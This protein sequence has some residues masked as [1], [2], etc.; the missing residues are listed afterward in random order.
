MAKR[1]TIS[2]EIIISALLTCP[3]LDKAAQMCG[4]SVR[5]LYERRQDAAFMQK[6]AEAQTQALATT[7]RFLQH[8]TGSAAAALLEIVE[9]REQPAQVRVTAA[10][11]ILE[12]AIR[13]TETV[14][15]GER[16]DALERYAEGEA[17]NE[18]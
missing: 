13:L 4:L 18:P 16:L 17:D 5:Q 7:T 2:N 1:E 6:L 15:F 9:N 10:K 14:D 3:T 11:A 8:A 12:Q